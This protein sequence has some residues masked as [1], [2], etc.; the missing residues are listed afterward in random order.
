[1]KLKQFYLVS[2]NSTWNWSVM[3]FQPYALRSQ[4]LAN[5][6]QQAP[7]FSQSPIWI[8]N[9]TQKFIAPTM[10]IRNWVLLFC[11]YC[12]IYLWLGY[13]HLHMESIFLCMYYFD[14]WSSTD[15]FFSFDAVISTKPC[16]LN[17]WL[18]FILCP[19]SMS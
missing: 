2:G 18:I 7:K 5:K 19:N 9:F 13:F 1:M 8:L 14:L 6:S 4:D 12:A 17:L 10:P 11:S 16:S 3:Y 15:F